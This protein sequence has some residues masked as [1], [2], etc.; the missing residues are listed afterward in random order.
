M[1]LLESYLH[2]RTQVRNEPIYLTLIL[3]QTL[4]F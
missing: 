1:D 3:L 4:E 2:E